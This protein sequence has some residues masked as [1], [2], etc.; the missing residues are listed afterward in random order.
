M[1]DEQ[2]KEV[3]EHSKLAGLMK[4]E[5]TQ[6][7]DLASTV[8]EIKEEKGKLSSRQAVK[9]Y[10]SIKKLTRHFTTGVVIKSYLETQK[11]FELLKFYNP[12]AIAEF[13]RAKPFGIIDNSTQEYKYLVNFLI[14]SDLFSK[15]LWQVLRRVSES[16][17]RPG[18]PFVSRDG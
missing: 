12:D 10:E 15:D 4:Q 9:C 5:A 17:D 11:N 18:N 2:R 8:R 14:G 13:A 3:S 1:S 6:T 7:A 16:I